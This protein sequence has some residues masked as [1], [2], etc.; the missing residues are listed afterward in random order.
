M[1]IYFHPT[2]LIPF[3]INSSF[4]P[5]IKPPNLGLPLPILSET[6]KSSVISNLPLFILTTCR[7]NLSSLPSSP[8]LV[9]CELLSL[10]Y[11]FLILSLLHIRYFLNFHLQNLNSFLSTNLI[12]QKSWNQ[13]NQTSIFTF[14]DKFSFYHN[15][16]RLLSALSYSATLWSIFI[17]SSLTIKLVRLSPFTLTMSNPDWESSAMHYELIIS[18]F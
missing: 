9:S 4:T 11:G 10:I 14:L 2:M 6:E 3:V 18:L 16:L 17:H 7:C 15:S 1:F 5:S 12:L 13:H 8:R